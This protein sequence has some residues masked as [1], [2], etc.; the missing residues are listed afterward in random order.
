MCVC[1]HVCEGL[2]TL[3]GVCQGCGGN[4]PPLV[5]VFAVVS[6]TDI[7]I[8]KECTGAIKCALYMSA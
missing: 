7:I 4:P 2:C 3:Q 8:E 1:V 5:V 6:E